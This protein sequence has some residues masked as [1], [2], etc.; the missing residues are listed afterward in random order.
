MCHR[1]NGNKSR[2]SAHDPARE[3]RP[4]HFLLTWV[5]SV[6]SSKICSNSMLKNHRHR[7][8]D[9]TRL[10]PDEKTLLRLCMKFGLFA[11]PVVFGYAQ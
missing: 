7:D 6:Y 11:F 8:A 9:Q 4:A 3:R 1:K 2:L 5:R 10:A